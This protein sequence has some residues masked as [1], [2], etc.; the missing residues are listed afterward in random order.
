MFNQSLFS[1]EGHSQFPQ[2]ICGEPLLLASSL[3]FRAPSSAVQTLSLA[4]VGGD[5]GTGCLE[6]PGHTLAGNYQPLLHISLHM[7]RENWLWLLTTV[8]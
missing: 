8:N 7:H 3:V 5:N 2:K 1:A 4:F 6:T